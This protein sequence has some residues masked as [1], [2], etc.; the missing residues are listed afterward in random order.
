LLEAEN[1]NKVMDIH[2]EL[3]K[4]KL[5]DFK[6]LRE[7]YINIKDNLLT[8][9]T[10]LVFLFSL[11]D[12]LEKKEKDLVKLKEENKELEIK[13]KT[14]KT[15]IKQLKEDLTSKNKSLQKAFENLTSERQQHKGSLEQLEENLKN[16]QQTISEF[17]RKEY[18]LNKEIKRMGDS[19]KYM[20]LLN[21]GIDGYKSHYR[22]E[23]SKELIEWFRQMEKAFE[24]LER[25]KSS[26]GK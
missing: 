21:V 26:A 1:Y 9:F 5:K 3:L 10:Y 23:P 11:Q 8:F 7:S 22:E 14:K 2:H 17:A 24:A 19:E 15:Q 18:D 13:V 12:R 4:A 16:A 20:T 25:E 6:E